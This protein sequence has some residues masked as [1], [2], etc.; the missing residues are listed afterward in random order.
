L[1][2]RAALAIALTA[3]LYLLYL[4]DVQFVL[5]DWWLFQKFERAAAPADMARAI[6][7]N[8]LWGA[9]RTNGL[10]FL[11]VYGLWG[12]AGWRPAF[13]FVVGVAL[14]GLVGYLLYRFVKRLGLGEGAALA[15][16][17]LFVALPTSHNPV[18]W[19]PACAH[20]LFSA[21]WLL[22]YLNSAA[23]PWSR[24][25]AAVQAGAVALASLS[26]DQVFGLL[27]GSAVCMAVVLRRRDL[28]RPAVVAWATMAVVGAVYIGWI[29]R[30]P[31][32]GSVAARFDFRPAEVLEHLAGIGE[33]YYK[34]SWLALPA[35]VAVWWLRVE[36]GPAWRAV[37][38]GAGLWVLG[39]GPTWFL[40]WRELRYNYLPSLGLALVLA[41]LCRKRLIAAA[42]LGWAAGTVVGEIQDCWRPM[43]RHTQAVIRELKKLENLRDHEIVAVAG[44]PSRIG[45]APHFGMYH[46]YSS[47]PFVESVTG[48]FGLYVGRA[49]LWDS[50]R[51]GLEHVDFFRELK[52]DE[53]RRAHVVVCDGLED[54]SIRTVL[55]RGGER[56]PLKNYRGSGDA[57]YLS[58]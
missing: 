23:G 45:T 1:R 39:Y 22:V 34:F 54:C 8:R 58:K 44:T 32:G 24:R 4:P 43:A 11:A 50:G 2:R 26:G 33:G 48:V 5:D 29:N 52:P 55:Q 6:L 31:V 7:E 16:G 41:A 19:F 40:R 51:L 25:A 36:S 57:V 53:L 13:Y 20:Y 21:A 46:S 37:W 3:S 42:L 12:L 38:L 27:A 14:H 9:F 15:A 17:M 47:T 10:S 30:A 35:A 56:Y 49:I 28:L 18:F